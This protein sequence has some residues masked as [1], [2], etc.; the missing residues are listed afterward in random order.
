[1][2]RFKNINKMPMFVNLL[3]LKQESVYSSL[4]DIGPTCNSID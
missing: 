2:E 3:L 4:V 1:M